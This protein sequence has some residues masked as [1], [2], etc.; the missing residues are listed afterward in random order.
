MKKVYLYKAI[1]T[2]YICLLSC[3]CYPQSKASKL[4]N[5]VLSSKSIEKA[6][7]QNKYGDVSV[8]QS[9]NDSI[10]VSYQIEASKKDLDHAEELLDRINTSINSSS[11]LLFI[12]V[13]LAK[14][15][16]K[17]FDRV[18]SRIETGD[19]KSDVNINLDL[20]L[21][22]K[23]NVEINNEFGNI[24]MDLKVEKFE[25]TLKH[26]DL[27][28]TE[29]LSELDLTHHY[30]RAILRDANQGRIILKNSRFECGSMTELNLI[31]KGSEIEINTVEKLRF[32]SKK[33]EAQIS[34]LGGANIQLNFSGLRLNSISKNL[35]ARIK[36]SDLRID[37]FE[38]KQQELDIDQDNSEID[39]DLS[40]T[41]FKIIGNMEKGTFRVPD[42]TKD[43]NVEILDED[44]NK[45][46]ITGTYG[47][48]VPGTIEIKGKKGYVLLRDY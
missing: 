4:Q 46:L 14:S 44:K 9:P 24:L 32:E 21:P 22:Q 7:V 12:D 28:V 48:D 19:D 5:E 31:S 13:T 38:G 33:D 25:C 18:F 1:A 39:I 34:A 29:N 27:R 47:N 43:A 17:F 8:S 45:R 3:L 15:E 20:K 35:D 26:G 11:S 40:N 41:S 42:L 10:Y 6:I 30:G 2:L 16:R 23:V 37:H 36:L